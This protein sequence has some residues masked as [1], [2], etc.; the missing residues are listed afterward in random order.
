[1]TIQLSTAKSIINFQT[2]EKS[3]ELERIC[4]SPEDLE[5]TFEE[6]EEEEEEE[7]TMEIND[8]WSVEMTAP[9]SLFDL[10]P[11]LDVEPL[12]PHQTW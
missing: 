6:E 1:M 2:H 11:K 3:I 7:K 12:A 4:S 9:A 10:S 8:S 5:V